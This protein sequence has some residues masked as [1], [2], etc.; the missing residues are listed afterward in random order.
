MRFD[1]VGVL[2]AGDKDRRSAVAEGQRPL[3]RGLNI[4]P[5]GTTT[6]PAFTAPCQAVA[7]SHELGT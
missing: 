3:R 1:R 6:A 2:E 5:T 7:Q 4:E